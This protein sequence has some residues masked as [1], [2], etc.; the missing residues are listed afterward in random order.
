MNVRWERILA[1]KS[2]ETQTGRIDVN[3]TPVTH[4]TLTGAPAMV[5][6]IRGASPLCDSARNSLSAITSPSIL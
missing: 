1:H 2:A 3:A 6:I 4:W 5:S